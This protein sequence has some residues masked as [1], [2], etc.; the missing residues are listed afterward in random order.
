MTG[1]PLAD[2]L[3]VA[4]SA[5]HVERVLGMWTAEKHEGQRVHFLVA[6]SATALA[7]KITD[8]DERDE[9]PGG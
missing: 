2:L 5:W 7:D 6:D 4:G 9:D 3:R 1:T 8:A